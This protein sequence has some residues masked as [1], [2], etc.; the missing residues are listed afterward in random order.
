MD[1]EQISLTLVQLSQ[2]VV[3]TPE[4]VEVDV[5]PLLVNK[6]G[7]LALDARIRISSASD[8]VID[9]LAIRPYPEELE[10]AI[11]LQSGR[12]LF[13]RPIR[14]EDELEHHAFLSRLTPQDVRFRFFGQVRELPHS[15]MARL[16]QIDFD[17]E[18]AFLVK[19]NSGSSA[20]ET[21]GVVRTVTD[22]DNERAEFSIVV[23][24]DMKGQGLG[25]ALLGK[26]ITYCRER[27]TKQMVGQILNDN[28]AMR[29]LVKH[30]GFK[31]R[32]VAEEGIMEAILVL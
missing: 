15:Q 2:L 27:G 21:L 3:D 22:P 19:E 28:T 16:T 8:N 26:M 31:T 18:M 5:N 6:E 4:I 32:Y 14:P 30:L 13:V 7:V 17:R 1:I 24:S 12:K 9:R 20:G 23:R 25:Q 29:G 11:T 10:E